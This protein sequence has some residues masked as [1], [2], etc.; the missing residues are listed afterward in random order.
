MYGTAPCRLN[1]DAAFEYYP[2]Y[3]FKRCKNNIVKHPNMLFM[4]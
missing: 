1:S 4:L 2:V 3:D